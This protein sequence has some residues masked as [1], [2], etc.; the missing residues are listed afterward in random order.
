MQALVGA[1]FLLSLVMSFSL[2]YLWGLINCLQLIVYLPLLN[3][4]FPANI[5][6]LLSV[7]IS[8]A[9]FDVVPFIDEI[10]EFLFVY[11]V[12]DV[13]EQQSSGWEALGFETKQ[14]VTNSGSLFLVAAIFIFSKIVE[15][16]SWVF[17]HYSYECVHIYRKWK[18]QVHST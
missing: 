12:N 16:V 13:N 15:K 8:V 3:V 9:T 11:T 6:M 14:F 17:G 7:L 5:N 2:Q 4:V 10:N 1:N 18:S